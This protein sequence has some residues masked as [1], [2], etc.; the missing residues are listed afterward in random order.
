[1]LTAEVRANGSFDCGSFPWISFT[2]AELK[3]IFCLKFITYKCTCTYTPPKL[4]VKRPPELSLTLVPQVS[5]GASTH[6]PMTV[7]LLVK[8][9]SDYPDRSVQ[10]WWIHDVLVVYTYMYTCIYMYVLSVSTC[11]YN[12]R[13]IFKALCMCSKTSCIVN[14]IAWHQWP[15]FF[16]TLPKNQDLYRLNYTWKAVILWLHT[17]SY[18]FFRSILQAHTSHNIISS[19]DGN[20]NLLLW[21]HLLDRKVKFIFLFNC[22]PPPL[23]S[24]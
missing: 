24:A 7:K 15:L 21:G 20:L 3:I 2:D 16:S 10:L 1:M 17:Q 6:R 11:N 18:V 14:P 13:P 23:T 12:S 5:M 9:P 4:Q 22:F 19:L 8:C